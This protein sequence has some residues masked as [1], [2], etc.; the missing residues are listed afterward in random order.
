MKKKLDLNFYKIFLDHLPDPILAVEK[1]NLSIK[2]INH[3]SEIFFSKSNSFLENKNL[4]QVFHENSYLISYLKKIVDEVG[5]YFIKEIPI[6]YSNPVEVKCIIPDKNIDFFFLILKKPTDIEFEKNIKDNNFNILDETISLLVHEINNPLS[7][8][9]LSSQIL[10]KKIFGE[11]RELIDIILNETQRIIKFLEK[12]NT[13]NSDF[14]SVSKSSENIHEILRYSLFKIKLKHE[15]IKIIE[16]FDPS[17][18]FVEIDKNLMTQVFENLI[19]NAAESFK[20]NDKP[21]IRI[22]TKFDYSH[23][24]KIPNVS[25]FQRKNYL[26]II[27]EDNGS[28]ISKKNQEKIFNPFFTTKKTGSGI[29]LY[30][31]KKIINLHNGFVEI[32]SSNL[33]TK[34][35]IKI[36]L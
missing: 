35:F 11:D 24:I 1:K 3:E 17:L 14:L 30:L 7:S 26:N 22:S 18:P 16:D 15:N 2:F 34:A 32:K 10:Q 25:N 12:L 5:E 20:S 31:V 4:N 36:P 19:L 9:T 27:I 8:I 21:Y 13:P 28:G 23:T 6:K 29:G 33:V